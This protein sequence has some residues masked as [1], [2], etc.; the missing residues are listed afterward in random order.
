MSSLRSL[1]LCGEFCL[2][3]RQE[4]GPLSVPITTT[5]QDGG[6]AVQLREMKIAA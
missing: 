2:A 5:I 6:A 1:C 4:A 3:R